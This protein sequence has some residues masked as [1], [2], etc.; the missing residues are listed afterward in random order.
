MYRHI[1]ACIQ[2]FSLKDF[3]ILLAALNLCKELDAG[4]SPIQIDANDFH[5]SLRKGNDDNDTNCWTSPS[6]EGFK[7]RG[8][9]YLK[10]NSKVGIYSIFRSLKFSKI[11]IYSF[12][13][14]DVV[15]IS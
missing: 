12:K 8:K 6:G 10:D 15:N 1:H 2:T 4:V 7:I 13:D 5:G 3:V 9:N 14:L 11:E